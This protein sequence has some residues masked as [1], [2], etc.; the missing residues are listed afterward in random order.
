MRPEGGLSDLIDSVA[1]GTS[2]DWDRI[3]P[4]ALDEHERRLLKQLRLVAGLADV[5]RSQVDDPAP[6]VANL[7]WVSTSGERWG[8]L[9]L[10]EKIGEGSYG[11]VYRAWDR[12]LFCDVAVKV[13]R[14]H[15]V[16][17]E[18]A[19]SGFERE[20][21][22]GMRLAHPNLVRVLR[23]GA[24]PPRPY[25]VMEYVGASFGKAVFS[26]PRHLTDE[27]IECYFAPSVSSPLRRAQFHAYHAA[28]HYMHANAVLHLDVKPEN[29]TMGDPPRLLDLSLARTIAGP[30][31]LRHSVGTGAYMAPE[32]CEHGIVTPQTDLFGLGATL[33]EGV[34]AMRPFPEGDLDHDERT[35]RYPQ[36][37]LDPPPLDE[38]ENVPASLARIVMS[39]LSR[40]PA[41]RPRSAVDV[42]VALHGVLE[43]FG[44]KE[45][46]AWPK[47]TRV[48]A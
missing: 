42:A 13:V 3:D 38:V 23:W 9:Q 7:P 2:V 24:E 48:R 40:D 41:R 29:V 30:M 46:F 27:V 34:S 19:I 37:T 15:R 17:E 28:L 4:A 39:C 36:L 20:V 1:D 6:P 8:H 33:Y 25:L 44:L 14:P 10:I 47:G 5:H 26:D 22:I 31:R 12:S 21:A 32:Q 16:D 18:R 45:L 11:E 43:G 35:E